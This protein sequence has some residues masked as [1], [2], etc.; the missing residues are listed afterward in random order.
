MR[1]FWNRCLH[2]LLLLF[3]SCRCVY[4]DFSVSSE[5]E[6]RDSDWLLQVNK[7]LTI[8][9][10]VLLLAAL[11]VPVYGAPKA[12]I[13]HQKP[14]AQA[15]KIVPQKKAEAVEPSR[16][17]TPIRGEFADLTQEQSTKLKVLNYRSGRLV[18][19][20][21]N[22]G[23]QGSTSLVIHE[24]G[25][26]KQ[27][28][29][30]GETKH[31]VIIYP[32]I[33]YL[34]YHSTDEAFDPMFSPDGRYVLFKFGQRQSSSAVY[35]FYVLDTQKNT[36]KSVSDR[37]VAYKFAL[38]SPDGKYIVFVEGGD[39]Y[40]GTR[41]AFSH[42]I[43]PLRT[44]IV[45]WRT[46][47]EHL[48]VENDTIF[49]PFSWIAPHTLLYGVLDVPGQ[50]LLDSL[51]FPK[52][53][54]RTDKATATKKAPA[55]PRP[56]IYEYSLE[57]SKSQLI[58]KDGYRPTPS[59]N[60]QRI[61]FY[62]SEDPANSLPLTSV[63]TWRDAPQGAALTVAQRDGTKRMALNI[64][65][66]FYPYV[67]WLKGEQLLT[68]QPIK[69]SPDAE[70]VVKEWNLQTQQFREVATLK[71]K[72]YKELHIDASK[73]YPVALKTDES[74]LIVLVSEV[75]GVS[76]DR[77][78]LTVVKSLQS[79]ELRTGVVTP[80]VQI[81]GISGIDWHEVPEAAN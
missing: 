79:V 57:T 61:A 81:S 45:D 28:D 32:I 50:W 11:C 39:K 65:G 1:F 31:A 71:A 12:R 51:L 73:F 49:G 35:F 75:T 26:V 58:I 46:G 67:Q 78:L 17:G 33:R 68:V 6:R 59:L 15:K 25:K 19:A 2:L 3:L 52:E 14:A 41:D 36:L 74:A 10:I 29:L 30:A 76:K 62:G 27:N 21:T 53:E 16:L 23:A 56:N 5:K 8:K 13:H 66:G 43:G 70:A 20:Y 63:S 69:D 54:K 38:W 7:M 77:P 55:T 24:I 9:P 40:G 34:P 64:E 48:V 22:R 42:Y 72:D 18:Y 37:V 80:L 60:G 4:S 47:K 44:Y